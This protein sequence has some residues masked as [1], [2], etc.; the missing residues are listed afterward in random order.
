MG[1][2]PAFRELTRQQWPGPAPRAP[3][4]PLMGEVRPRRLLPHPDPLLLPPPLR[5]VL[6][7]GGVLN[8]SW[9]FPP[10][11]WFRP[12]THGVRGCLGGGPP[13][14]L[15]GVL[16][17]PPLS[18]HA[19]RLGCASIGGSPLGAGGVEA[20]V[21]LALHAIC[22]ERTLP[23]GGVPLFIWSRPARQRRMRSVPCPLI[24]LLAW[25][26]PPLLVWHDMR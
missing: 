7:W 8:R 20:A 3:P 26:V 2:P 9:G 25:G 4:S 19:V 23:Y 10:I 16:P 14:L 13:L 5:F 15:T 6:R 24:F 22:W 18:L 1:R 12:R 21:P 11:F 17:H